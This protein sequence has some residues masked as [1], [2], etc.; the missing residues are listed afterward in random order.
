MSALL[1]FQ[2]HLATSSSNTKS[3]SLLPP[4]NQYLFVANQRLHSSNFNLKIQ[5]KCVLVRAKGDSDDESHDEAPVP[6]KG[7]PAPD[8]APVPPK[9]FPFEWKKW[10]VGILF[11]FI[12]P[13]Y[14]LKMGPLGILKDKV[15]EMFETAETAAEVMEDLAELVERLADKAEKKLPDGTKLDDLAKAIENLAGQVDDKAEQAQELIKQVQN[16]A[17]DIEELMEAKLLDATRKDKEPEDQGTTI[18]RKRLH[19]EANQNE[20][21]QSIEGLT[22]QAEKKAEEA[23]QLVQQVDKLGHDI[24]KMDTSSPTATSRNQETGHNNKSVKRLTK[25]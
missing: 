20:G 4:T 23:Q 16:I 18:H 2:Y 25:V 7:P 8:E 6:P 13:S 11:F 12:L 3:C 21:A 24:K 14:R 17:E 19:D 1:Q 15:D 5:V 22:E 9:R 10:A